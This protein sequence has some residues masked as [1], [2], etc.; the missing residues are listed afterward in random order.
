M[1]TAIRVM[2]F[3]LMVAAFSFGFFGIVVGL[4]IIFMHLVKLESFGTPYLA[5]FAPLRVKDLKDTFIRLPIWKLNQR[6]HD[7]HPQRM[8]QEEPSR[9]WKKDEDS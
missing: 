9:G 4:I 1:S 2:R 8:K 6:P 7:P 5:P 3:P